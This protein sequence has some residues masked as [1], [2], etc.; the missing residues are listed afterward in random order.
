MAYKEKRLKRILLI[1][2]SSLGDVVLIHPVI[3]KLYDNGFLVDILIKEEYQNVFKNNPYINNILLLKRKVSIFRI[4]K[5]IQK[6]KY[7]KIIDLHKNLRSLL[8]SIFFPFKIIK[9]KKYKLKRWLLVNFKI[10]FLKDNSV[11][12]NYLNTL[13]K[14]KIEVNKSD[15]NYNIFY[16]ASGY[17][18]DKD[19]II[20][21][22]FSKWPTKEWPYYLDLI[23]RLN[24]EIIILGSNKEYFR[25]EK[26]KIR[27][28]II[29]LCGKIS[30]DK[31][32][33][34]LS[35]SGLLIT[36]D[37]ALLHIGA[38]TNIPII[39]FFGS[40]TRELGFYPVRGN[41][42]IFEN[43]NLLCRPCAYHGRLKCPYSH[44]RCM[45]D[46][47]VEDVLQKIKEM[48]GK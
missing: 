9:Y 15:F 48:T 45:N 8:I 14:L 40:T 7:K 43:K 42:F 24:N 5:E 13:K 1:R 39:A 35:K 21:S 19:R 26:L 32:P 33:D 27:S 2:F 38:G 29:N 17:N 37:S 10:N 18:V 25:G 6:N 28:N 36:N 31:I 12:R 11:V 20:I 44:F 23:Q 46:I 34:L 4:I 41:I 47:R 22:P 30:L 16:T 3:K